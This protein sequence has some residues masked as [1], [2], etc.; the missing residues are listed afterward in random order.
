MLR[1]IL[2][3]DEVVLTGITQ[4]IVSLSRLGAAFPLPPLHNRNILDFFLIRSL[5]WCRLPPQCNFF[6]PLCSLFQFKQLGAGIGFRIWMQKN[7][8]LFCFWTQS[9]L[10]TFSTAVLH[11]SLT[12][13]LFEWLFINRGYWWCTNI[14]IVLNASWNANYWL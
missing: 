9:N 1:N 10:S 8:P 5:S 3:G 11:L 12:C 7:G 14:D 2:D 4:R 13:Y 6:P